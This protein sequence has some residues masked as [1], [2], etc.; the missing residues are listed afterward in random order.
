MSHHNIQAV[1]L[2]IQGVLFQEGSIIDGAPE[3]LQW[4]AENKIPFVCSTNT[5]TRTRSELAERFQSYG[6]SISESQTFFQS[7]VS[8]LPCSQESILMVGDD[9]DSDIAGARACGLQTCQVRTGK[10]EE[11]SPDVARP[12]P[13][14]EIASIADLPAVIESS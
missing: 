2:D 10:Y 11:I 4:L 3:T 5:T 6:F 9:P 7:A 14:H 12:Q 13:D 1:I 8:S